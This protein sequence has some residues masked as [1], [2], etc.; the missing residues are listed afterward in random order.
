MSRIRYYEFKDGCLVLNVTFFPP[1][2]SVELPSTFS[3]SCKVEAS[4]KPLFFEVPEVEN[5][6]SLI[7]LEEIEFFV[8]LLKQ[9]Y[10][11]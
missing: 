4:D 6:S 1:E 9:M 7:L 2:D 5:V 8:K 3:L 10:Y 11:A